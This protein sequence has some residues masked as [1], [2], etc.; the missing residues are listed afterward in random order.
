[1]SRMIGYM[2]T[3]PTYGSWL[4]GGEKGYTKHGKRC[5]E[6][7]RLLRA[8]RKFLQKPAVKLTDEQKLLVQNEIYKTAQSIGQEI[9]S[10]AVC[11]NHVHIVVTNNDEPIEK[12]AQRYKRNTTYL[13]NNSG[14]T[15][16]V[17]AT[18]YDK[19]YSYDNNDLQVRIEYVNQHHEDS[20]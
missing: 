20:W 9:L 8:N 19:R 16:K 13:M 3:W 4:Q 5:G 17:W 7:A 12:V 10:L 1:M 6:D 15:G 2:L 11:S 14:I 18:G